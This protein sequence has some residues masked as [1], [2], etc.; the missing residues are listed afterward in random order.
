MLNSCASGLTVVNI[1]NGFGAAFA[2]VLM[3][4]I[5]ERDFAG[6][7]NDGGA[8]IVLV[9]SLDDPRK[10]DAVIDDIEI[11]RKSIAFYRGGRDWF[12]RHLIVL[13]IPKGDF[14]FVCAIG[15][16]IQYILLYFLMAVACF[17]AFGEG[18]PGLP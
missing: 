7:F 6:R 13:I 16:M 12:Y 9:V 3:N 2:A 18:C 4:T 15:E 11:R 17:D 8:A 5:L 10:Q 1:D 14:R